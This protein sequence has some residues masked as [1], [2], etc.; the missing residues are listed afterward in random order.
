V[1]FLALA[2]AFTA[3]S[4]LGSDETPKNRFD[5][6]FFQL[7]SAAPACPEPRGPLMTQEEAISDTHHRLERGQRCYLEKRCRYSSSYQYDPEIAQAIQAAARDGRFKVPEQSSL[8][9][10]VQGRRVFAYGCV[11]SGYR[12]G[13]L[14]DQ[15]RTIPDVEVAVEDVRIGPRGT[16]GYP[17]R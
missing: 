8:W 4:A 16:V 17:T 7:S 6:P 15:L 12:A 1:R 10:L 9:I 14:R 5:D 2:F 11:P 3:A 13:T